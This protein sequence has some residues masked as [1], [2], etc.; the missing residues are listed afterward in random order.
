MVAD[1]WGPHAT[2]LPLF[3]YHALNFSINIGKSDLKQGKLL[4]EKKRRIGTRSRPVFPM[5]K[6][7]TEPCIDCDND[8]KAILLVMKSSVKDTDTKIDHLNNA[9]TGISTL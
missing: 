2:L 8:R 3:M 4:F 6:A 7:L 1:P 5:P 9:E